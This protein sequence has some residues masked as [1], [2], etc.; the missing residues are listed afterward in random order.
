[1]SMETRDHYTL[2]DT[3]IGVCAIAW[4]A[5][6]LTHFRLP[7]PGRAALEAR[8]QRR[9]G[10]TPSDDPPAPIK[11]LIA[12]VQRYFAGEEV[13]FSGVAVD[14]SALSEFQQKLYQSLRAVGWGHTTTYGELA[15]ALGCP[16]A[17]DVGQAMGK[18]PVPIIVPCHRVLAAG[19]KIGGFSAPGGAVTKEKLL[20]LEGVHLAGET[21]RLPGL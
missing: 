20:A 16:D 12:D 13:D 15:R 8:I 4:N 3:A 1:M 19:G 21:P 18:N 2:F 5:S 6:G 17:R 10:G 11:A 9:S 14:L 7:G